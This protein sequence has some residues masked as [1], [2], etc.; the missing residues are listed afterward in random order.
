MHK[1]FVL[2]TAAF[3]SIS[4]TAYAN[5][6]FSGKTITWVVPFKEGGG[7]SRFARFIQPFLTKYLPGNPDIQVMHI[8]GGGAIKGS[9]YFQKNA[10]PDGTFIFGCS[11]SVIVN[12]ATGNPLVEYNLSEY[13]PVLLLPQNT[14][15]FTRSD[16]VNEPHDMSKLIERDLVLYALKTPASADLFHIWVFDKL[17]L[18]GAKPIPGLSS[19]GGYQAFL[20]GEIHISSHGAANYVK[21]VKPEIDKGKIVDLMTLGIIDADGTVSRNP[22]APNAPTFPE[23]YEK[24]N[25]EKLAGDD[26]EA[27]YSIG[28]AWSQASKSM[29][30]PQGTPDEIV[31]AFRDAATKMV[32]DPEFKEKATKALGPFPLII[33]EEAGA[34]VKKAAIFS[35]KTKEQLN[36]VL[37]KNRF[38]YRVK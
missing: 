25:G 17:G 15:W 13:R 1:L 28:A 10:V 30:L 38:T 35:D 33:G 26:L 3:L 7:T 12:V 37:K 5:V 11:T 24:I 4:S 27:F 34:I 32:N 6:D 16:L 31:Q 2:F 8:P 29:L 21:K 23:M 20:R 9:N 14:H 19:S 22:L 36:N 18:K